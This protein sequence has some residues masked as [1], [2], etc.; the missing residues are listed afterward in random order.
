VDAVLA[1]CFAFAGPRMKLDANFAIGNFIRD[2]LRAEPIRILEDGTPLR[3]YLY[4]ADLA[5]WLWTLYFKG[6]SCRP[7]HVGSDLPV[8]I[9]RLA[10]QVAEVLHPGLPVTVAKRPQEGSLPSCYVP[11]IDTARRELGLAPWIDL[12]ETIRRTGA[13]HQQQGKGR[14]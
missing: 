4:A 12:E 7:V 2:A 9:S 14:E 1:R 8:A 13:W 5:I 11:A 10:T 3:S 6:P